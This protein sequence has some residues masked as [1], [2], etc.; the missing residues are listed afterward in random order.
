MQWTEHEQNEGKKGLFSIL[1]KLISCH[2]TELTRGLIYA[3]APQLNLKCEFSTLIVFEHVSLDHCG[4]RVILAAA[5]DDCGQYRLHA[6]N[7]ISECFFNSIGIQM[8][9]RD[10]Q[11][12]AKKGLPA[13]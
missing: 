8:H 10:V 4:N 11:T 2:F 12:R 3:M 9:R 7:L 6:S 1:M 5:E 13:L